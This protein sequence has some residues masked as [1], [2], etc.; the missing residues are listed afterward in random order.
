M[1]GSPGRQTVEATSV[2]VGDIIV[3]LVERV[4]T[5]I[6][7]ALEVWGDDDDADELDPAGF[8]FFYDDRSPD[9]FTH[10]EPVIIRRPHL[11]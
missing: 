7:P 10:D 5:D 4:V 11:Y 8:A 6:R 2:E 9:Y 1:K 3:G